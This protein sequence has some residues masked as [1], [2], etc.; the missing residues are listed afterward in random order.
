MIFLCIL[1]H[2]DGSSMMIDDCGKLWSRS[3]I[4]ICS[5]C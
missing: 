2:D 3:V 4:N 1:R 5:F